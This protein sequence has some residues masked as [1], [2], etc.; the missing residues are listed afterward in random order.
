MVDQVF[1]ALAGEAA[2]REPKKAARRAA[3]TGLDSATFIFLQVNVIVAYY[4]VII[5]IAFWLFLDTWS[6]HLSLLN[7]FGL[8][9]QALADPLLPAM[10]F[11]ISG[12][13]LGS[14]LYNIRI[15]FRYYLKSSS[16]NY[17]W[18][19]KYISAPVESAAMA[20]LVFALIQGGLALIGG[21]PA[22]E[23]DST[24]RFASF[25]LGAMV[26]FGMRDV[27]GWMGNLARTMFRDADEKAQ[28]E[29][30]L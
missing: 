19:A 8:G 25:G 16:F 3:K 21:P 2:D 28:P 29:T 9:E 30:D 23:Q 5:L 12:G 24:S 10:V 22:A 13:I 18:F 26:G 27:V 20:L 4:M 15:L 7:L 6:N 11:S 14:V 17:R 1:G